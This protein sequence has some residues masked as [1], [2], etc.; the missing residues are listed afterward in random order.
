MLIKLYARRIKAKRRKY[1][2]IESGAHPGDNL[3]VNFNYRINGEGG[4]GRGEEGR[5]ENVI[6]RSAAPPASREER[7]AFIKLS[8]NTPKECRQLDVRI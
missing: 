1:E 6:I 4:G 7:S 8:W 5:V 3:C 2:F